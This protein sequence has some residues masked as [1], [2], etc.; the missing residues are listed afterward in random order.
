MMVLYPQD[1]YKFNDNMSIRSVVYS[2]INAIVNMLSLENIALSFA[3][4]RVS[5]SLTLKNSLN[6]II[7]HLYQEI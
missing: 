7:L 2:F 6:L 4:Q 1:S 5:Y 3:M